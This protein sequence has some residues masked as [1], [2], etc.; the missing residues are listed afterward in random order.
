M[1]RH[2]PHPDLP[3]ARHLTP[4][5]MNNLHFRTAGSHTPLTAKNER[6]ASTP[7]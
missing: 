2:I 3:G 1:I 6:P 4:L 5:E 7:R